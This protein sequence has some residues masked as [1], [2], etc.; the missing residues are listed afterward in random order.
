MSYTNPLV[1]RLV[2]LAV[3]GGAYTFYKKALSGEEVQLEQDEECFHG[4]SDQR[5]P[6]EVTQDPS[7]AVGKTFTATSRFFCVPQAQKHIAEDYARGVAIS[8]FR[9]GDVGSQTSQGLLIGVRSET[10]KCKRVIAGL[11][12]P[13]GTQL[14]ITSVQKVAPASSD[15]LQQSKDQLKGA[16]EW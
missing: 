7:K 2:G 13:T 15:E 11:Y 4:T 10:Q 1:T 16:D 9:P 6:E 14:T 5:G 8:M 3:T 12:H